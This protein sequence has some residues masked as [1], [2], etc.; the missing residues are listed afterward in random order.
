MSIFHSPSKATFS[1]AIYSTQLNKPLSRVQTDCIKRSR[2]ESF[3]T[4]CIFR[5]CKIG[6]L[7]YRVLQSELRSSSERAFKCPYR[8][9]TLNASAWVVYLP[10]RKSHPDRKDT[11]YCVLRS[12]LRRSERAFTWKNL[13][14]GSGP[15]LNF[16]C[17]WWISKVQQIL[18]SGFETDVT[19]MTLNYQFLPFP[20]CLT[21]ECPQTWPYTAK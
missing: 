3:L 18:N 20:L 6:L 4:R 16:F 14:I 19:L 13:L 9:S 5:I 11:I 10:M 12:E 8:W 21:T 2:I 1:T 15:E 7:P 17:N